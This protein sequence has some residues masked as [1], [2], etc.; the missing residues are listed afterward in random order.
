[1]V[2][3]KS[4]QHGD[5]PLDKAWISANREY[6]NLR[7]AREKLGMDSDSFEIISPLGEKGILG[8]TGYEESHG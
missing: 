7:L 6:D 2:V 5:I 8:F 4:F 3:G 1:M